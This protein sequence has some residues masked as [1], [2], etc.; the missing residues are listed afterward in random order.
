[1]QA[2]LTQKS[3]EHCEGAG[4]T[5]L[6]LRSLITQRV[7]AAATSNTGTIKRMALKLIQKS[8]NCLRGGTLAI[9]LLH[10][11]EQLKALGETTVCTP[12]SVPVSSPSLHL[13]SPYPAS[14][15]LASS[16]SFSFSLTT[17]KCPPVSNSTPFFSFSICLLS[18]PLLL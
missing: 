3:A 5:E 9:W 17:S 12:L 6:S 18:H 2:A 13:S 8:G 15:P 14:F 16:D 4:K 1:M 11:W 10:R 7:S